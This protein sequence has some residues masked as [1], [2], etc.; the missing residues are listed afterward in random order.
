MAITI[1]GENNNDR[2]TATDGVIDTISGFNIAGII[3]ASSFTGDLTGDVT[4]NLT[5]NIN[6][7]T[8]LLQT[9]GSE[10]F[11]I[12][13]NNELGIAGAN[14]GTSGQ[15][16]T[17]GGSGNAVSWT[18]IPT[19]VSLSSNADNRI[20]TGGSGVNLNGEANLTFDGNTLVAKNTTGSIS[21][22]QTKTAEFWREDGTRNPRLEI[23]HNQ[24]GSIISHTY[25]T[26]ASHLMFHNSNVERIRITGNGDVGIG[27]LSDVEKKVDIHTGDGG[28]VV[29]RPNGNSN[30]SRGNA[31]A[32]N[33]LLVMRMSYGDNAATSAN[34]GARI[35]LQFTGRNDSA[36]YADDP[37]KSASV[38]GV[39]EDSSAGYTR[40]MG[41]AFYTSPHDAAQTE[42]M[43]ITADGITILKNFNGVGLRLEGSGGNFQ[44]MQLKTTDSSGSQTRSV[45][46]DVVNENGVTVANQVGEIRSDGG[47]EWRW[48]TQPAGTS[49]TATNGRTTKMKID[50]NGHVTLPY[51]VAFSARGGP[52]DISN[53]VIVFGTQ[54]FQRGGTNYSTST[55]IFT[56]PITGIYHFMCN[57][58]RY[59]NSNDSMIIL[60]KSTNGGGNWTYELEYRHM[61]NYDGGSGR[62]WFSF[63]MSQLIDL[64]T[65]DQ[66]RIRAINRVHCNGVYSRFSGFLVA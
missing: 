48:D 9:G 21:A 1:S 56:A 28:S 19:Q 34:A 66:V 40:K 18:T 5:G 31:N 14:Y 15:V 27:G 50:S 32:V 51:Q 55:G 10:R 38:Y 4:G 20:I 6:N 63:G 41:L 65:N 42:K 33:N 58:Y 46:I 29:I 3:T 62:G 13:G 52:A 61:N 64:N 36:G 26:G 25:S 17:S 53:N 45:F 30:G 39:S 8:L 59:E 44:G 43:R 24:E 49:R 37:G 2:I 16:L 11:R 12:T 57:P 47:S 35:G 23:K 22:T 60:E 7:S 54:V